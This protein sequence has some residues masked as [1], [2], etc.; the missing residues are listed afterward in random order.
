M[1]EAFQATPSMLQ[2]P[3][4]AF[5]MREQLK[6]VSKQIGV[7]VSQQNFFLDVEIRVPR[8]LHVT[9]YYFSFDIFCPTVKKF[10]QMNFNSQAVQKQMAGQ[11]GLQAVVRPDLDQRHKSISYPSHWL[12]DKAKELSDTRF[13]T[14]THSIILI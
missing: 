9:K 1:F 2:S 8:N 4:S 14:R 11:I 3:S 13:L 10:K 7:A 6:T 5:V 12:R